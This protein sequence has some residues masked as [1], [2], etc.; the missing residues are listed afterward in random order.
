MYDL[1]L[2]I[3]KRI[4]TNAILRYTR[5]QIIIIIII[6]II[7]TR[8]DNMFNQR[9]DLGLLVHL[10]RRMGSDPTRWYINKGSRA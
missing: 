1:I 9:Q 4:E 5:T 2:G 6:I 7:I 8:R 10:R 3:F